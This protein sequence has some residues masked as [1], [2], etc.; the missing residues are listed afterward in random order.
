[1]VREIEA[2]VSDSLRVPVVVELRQRPGGTIPQ[3][4][5]LLEKERSSEIGALAGTLEDEYGRDGVE[6]RMT[7]P[8]PPYTFVAR[9]T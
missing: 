2:R 5:V 3:I 6:L 1:M 8:W 7:G 4:N 9:Q